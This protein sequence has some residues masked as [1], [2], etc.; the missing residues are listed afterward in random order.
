MPGCDL[1]GDIYTFFPPFPL[2]ELKRQD[3]EKRL[4]AREEEQGHEKMGQTIRGE[5]DNGLERI[6]SG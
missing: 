1:F 3:S 5:L 4:G 6:S 2:A